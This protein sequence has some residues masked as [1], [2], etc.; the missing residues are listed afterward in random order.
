[1]IETFCLVRTRR[2]APLLLAAVPFD[3][4]GRDA[5]D[6]DQPV[7]LDYQGEQVVGFVA[8]APEQIRNV[9]EVPPAARILAAGFGTSDVVAAIARDNA[10]ALQVA[11]G[12][13]GSQ[14]DLRDAA[15]HGDRARL[16]FIL[17]GEPGDERE[18]IRDRLASAFRAEIRFAWPGGAEVPDLGEVP[19]AGSERGESA[20]SP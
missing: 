3:L 4:P 15:W 17:G 2:H 13:A 1:M 16:T 5:L 14:A 20:E 18:E 9:P 11:R 19:E 8:V 7:L 12:I 10:A 6:L